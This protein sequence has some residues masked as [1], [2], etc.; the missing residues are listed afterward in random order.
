MSN[1]NH[2]MWGIAPALFVFAMMSPIIVMEL[3]DNKTDYQYCLDRCGKYFNGDYIDRQC[4]IQCLE[5]L[6]RA[7][8]ITNLRKQC[9]FSKG[10]NL[11]NKVTVTWNPDTGKCRVEQATVSKNCSW[12]HSGRGC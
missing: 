2:W 7:K 8:Q 5:V 11:D 1:E 4:P 3:T 6:N 10:L 12:D 9:T